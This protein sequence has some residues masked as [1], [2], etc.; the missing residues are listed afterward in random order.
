[1]T[2]AA[3]SVFVFGIYLIVLGSTLVIAPNLLVSIF[4]FAPPDEPWVRVAGMLALIIGYY[5]VQCARAEL[6]RFLEL[7]VAA[8]FAVPV[9]FAAFVVLAF[10]KPALL[11]FGMADLAG[12][13]WTMLALR[14]D[15]KAVAPTIAR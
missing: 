6:R 12:A 7:T 9:F 2:N 8:R 1:M 5:Y 11:L 14:S 15:A 4:G 13:I 3:R 10:A